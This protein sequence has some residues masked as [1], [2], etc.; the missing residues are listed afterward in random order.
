MK[1]IVCVLLI[2]AALALPALASPTIL[3]NRLQ[4]VLDNITLAPN[5]G[6]SS[7]D[8]ATDMISDDLDSYWELTASSSSVKALVYKVTE[9]GFEDLGTFG[10]FDAADPTKIVELFDGSV[11]DVGDTAVLTILADGSV[12][13]SF[14]DIDNPANSTIGDSGVD[15][16]GNLFGYYLDTEGLGAGGGGFWYSQTALNADGGDHMAAYQGLDIDT[17]QLPGKSPG[18]WTDNEFMLAW[19]IG[20]LT[21]GADQDYDD[22]VVLVESV[23]P[24]PA[25]GAVVLGSLGVSIVGW[26]KRR[27]SLS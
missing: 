5:P 14:T 12:I 6:D 8:V 9:A 1:K 2:T 11:V 4:T 7:V 25:P 15:F 26:I 17:I 23:R 22:F 24:I 20:D 10:V 27:R 21:E 18:L 3:T 19:E 13:R 16:A